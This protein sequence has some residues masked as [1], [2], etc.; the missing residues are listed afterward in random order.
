M[1]KSAAN[2]AERHHLSTDDLLARKKWVWQFIKQIF[3]KKITFYFL[4]FSSALM[5]APVE[6]GFAAEVGETK[7]FI[8]TAYYSPLP[9]QESYYRGSYEAD[10]ALNGQGIT[11]SDG[12]PV[13]VGMI[14]AP[15][16]YEFGTK[17]NLQWLGVVSVHDRGGSI[18][19]GNGYD[20]ID[21]WMGSGDEGL[22]R[23]IAWGRREI[24]GHIV[25]RDT[26]VSLDIENIVANAPQVSQ[27]ALQKLQD[28]GYNT[29]GKTFAENILQFQL[30]HGVISSKNEPGAG[31]YG[32]KTTAKLAQLHRDFQ[33]HGKPAVKATH[34]K[35]LE[36]TVEYTH[37]LSESAATT[38]SQNMR[39]VSMG[40]RA[41]S[42]KNLQSFLADRGLYAGAEDGVMTVSLLGALRKYQ[43]GHNIAQT[44]RVD[45]RTQQLIRADLM[46]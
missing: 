27:I 43:H 13:Y 25:A 29:T 7:T 41:E 34:A 23:T 6:M 5:I 21:I 11:A 38:A 40:E 10:K 31:N 46:K 26:P 39:T 28:I 32:P 3:Q 16:G 30:D 36:E 35:S 1:D 37:H 9:N 12:T 4:I 15:R 8:A 42:V 17:I 24:M 2:F 22:R 18:N 20:R 44:G 33:R 14:A 19:A 45:I